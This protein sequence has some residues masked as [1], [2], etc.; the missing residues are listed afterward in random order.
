MPEIRRDKF[1]E[2]VINPKDEFARLAQ[3]R[4]SPFSK[5]DT[6]AAGNLDK[7]LRIAIDTVAASGKNITRKRAARHI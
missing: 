1:T 6:E 3:I 7:D 2:G 5:A 4:E